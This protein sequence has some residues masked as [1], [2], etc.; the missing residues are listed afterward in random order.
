[1]EFKNKLNNFFVV[2]PRCGEDATLQCLEEAKKK[3][4]GVF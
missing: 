3:P 4:R 2:S 1:M